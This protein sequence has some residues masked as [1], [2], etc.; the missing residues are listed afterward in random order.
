ML[1]PA[2]IATRISSLLW[3]ILVLLAIVFL[4]LDQ[5][6]HRR[7]QFH[8]GHDLAV[9]CV[10]DAACS[11]RKMIRRAWLAHADDLIDV[12][13]DFLTVRPG[14]QDQMQ[15]DFGNHPMRQLV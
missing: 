12:E 9:G 15:N 2:L 5:S 6:K 4:V 3:L 11:R 10:D 8:D 1:W 14:Q 13:Q 7:T